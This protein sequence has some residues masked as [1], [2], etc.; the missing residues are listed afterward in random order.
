MPILGLTIGRGLVGS[1]QESAPYV[2][3]ALLVVVG[4]WGLLKAWRDRKRPR[5]PERHVGTVRLLLVALALSMDNLA[6]GF[7]LAGLH[8]TLIQAAAAFGSAS[9]AMSLLGLELGRRI[10]RR[11]GIRSEQVG[12]MILVLVGIILAARLLS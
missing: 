12:N 4:A 11:I 2:G 10:G 6:A 3:A 7:A 5:S 1:F 9:A 8:V